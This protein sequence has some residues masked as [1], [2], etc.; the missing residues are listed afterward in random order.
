MDVSKALTR[1]IRLSTLTP[2]QGRWGFTN[3]Q[4]EAR[5]WR[6][7]VRAGG[8]NTGTG[9]HNQKEIRLCQEVQSSSVKACRR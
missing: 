7:V 5:H 4:H 8:P 2:E 1:R 9:G 6:P 3:R